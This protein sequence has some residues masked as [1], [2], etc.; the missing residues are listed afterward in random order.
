MR[1]DILV[2]LQEAVH[3][4][5]ML[6][7]EL[8]DKSTRIREYAVYVAS[9]PGSLHVESVTR[10]W[11]WERGYCVC[12]QRTKTANLLVLG[13]LRLAPV[14]CMCASEKAIISNANL[15]PRLHCPAFFAPCKT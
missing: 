14:M 7:S 4:T 6:N 5:M 12:I 11:A 3:A 9:S 10:T 2:K 1:S 8:S 13:P 15:V